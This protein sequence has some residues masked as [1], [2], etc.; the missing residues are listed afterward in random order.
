MPTYA[1]VTPAPAE[2]VTAGVRAGRTG[3]FVVPD[4]RGTGVL[5]DRPPGRGSGAKW[6]CEPARELVA[7]TGVPAWVLLSVEDVAGAYLVLPGESKPRPLEWVGDWE[8]SADPAAAIVD[9]KE[10]DAYCQ[11][12]AADYGMGDRGPALAAVRND[13]APDRPPVPMAQLLRGLCRALGLPEATVGYSLLEYSDPGLPAAVR[14]EVAGP[15]GK[16]AGPGGKAAGPGGKAAGLSGE[17]P[18]PE[19]SSPEPSPPKPWPARPEARAARTVDVGVTLIRRPVAA[20]SGYAA[21]TGQ[22]AWTVP[23]GRQWSWIAWDGDGVPAALPTT[24]EILT[25]GEREPA[26][27]VWWSA[28][29]AGF[30]LAVNGH[31]VAAHEWGGDAH[32][33]AAAAGRLSQEFRVPDEQA[34]IAALLT[35]SGGDPKDLLRELL[36]ILRGPADMVGLDW[37]ALAQRAAGTPGAVHTAK[38]STADALRQGFRQAMRDDPPG[39]GYTQVTRERPGWYRLL[40]LV[41]AIAM[42]LSTVILFLIWRWHGVSGWWVVTGVIVTAVFAWDARPRSRRSGG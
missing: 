39:G 9:R 18:H 14:V 20:V 23:L 25:A 6:L 29:A 13:P 16:A 22:S 30:A 26:L 34:R 11:R 12:L 36:M 21:M 15:G 7:T 17:V 5:F 37:S 4:P 33:P 3:G 42:A 31:V 1:V 10:W 28:E 19:P 38:L 35:R 40:N 24:A 8:P 2:A 32:D 41:G 27:S